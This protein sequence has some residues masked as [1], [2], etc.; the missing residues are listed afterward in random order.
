MSL[1]QPSEKASRRLALLFFSTTLA[2][3]AMLISGWLFVRR[4]TL[5]PIPE[6]SP[7]QQASK[8]DPV[9]PLLVN[10]QLDLPG[11]GEVFPALVASDVRDY[12]P[13]ANLSI[14]NTSPEPVLQLVS[15]EIPGWT[16]P[17]EET[18]VVGPRESRTLRI[19]PTLL[20]GAYQ[21]EEI[22]R[23]TLEV[24]IRDLKS[25]TVNAQSRP[26]L[27]HGGS[28]VYWGR[29][30]ANAQIVARWVTP[31][32]PAVLRLVSQARVL[33]PTGRMHGYN[34]AAANPAKLGAE[35][36]AQARAVFEALKRSGLSYVSSMFTF[37]DFTTN[38]QRIRLPRETLELSNANC[39]DV[40]VV[41][42]SAME[43]LGMNPVIVIVPGHAF[44]GVRLGPQTSETLYLDLTVLPNGSF[45]HAIER[46]GSWMKKTP[47]EQVLTV[48]IA[49]ARRLGIYPLPVVPYQ[50]T[51]Q[52]AATREQAESNDVVS[53]SGTNH[54]QAQR[55]DSAQ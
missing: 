42:A 24:R 16:Q 40:S 30:F 28:D 33:T 3:A 37:G 25:G 11:R 7:V 4:L 20:P 22:R 45:Q 10:Y 26:V 52:R 38:A 46:A 43:N 14:V 39:I 41:F 6:P 13:L 2:L 9:S 53:Y 55:R 23:G 21:L 48:D 5:V 15:A 1:L 44:V 51:S 34:P 32:D 8:A 29:Q 47:A 35:V 27:I 49:S 31:H 36:R 54:R 17:F 12:W 19:N 50:N 18:I